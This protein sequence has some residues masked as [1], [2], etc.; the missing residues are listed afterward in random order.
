MDT[1]TESKP[2]DFYLKNKGRVQGYTATKG[3]PGIVWSGR[4]CFTLSQK[5]CRKVTVGP[6]W[7]MP[8]GESYK[9]EMAEPTKSF[10]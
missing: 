7:T 2:E 10:R 9:M 6:G 1:E 3:I 5:E 4:F 8:P